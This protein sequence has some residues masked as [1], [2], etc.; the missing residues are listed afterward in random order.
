MQFNLIP[1]VSAVGGSDKITKLELDDAS[2]LNKINPL[3]NNHDKEYTPWDP[4]GM[5]IGEFISRALTFLFPLAGIILFV[6]IIV[7]GIQ[8]ASAG[9]NGNSSLA[10][11]GKQRLTGAIIGFII[12]ASAYG[13]ML[14][15]QKLLGV[16]FLPPNGP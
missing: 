6:M 14:L 4:N 3:Y 13:I 1:K 10:D 11:R 15:I 7:S 8:V 16:T 2:S 12:T 5:T 9:I